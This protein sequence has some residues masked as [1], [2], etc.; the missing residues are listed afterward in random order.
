MRD[1]RTYPRLTDDQLRG[2]SCPTLFIAGEY[3]QFAPEEE[4]KRVTRLIPNSRY[5]VVPGGSHRP[6]MSR[7]NPVFVNDT[8]LQFLEIQS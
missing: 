2:I 5:V 4:L 3:D 6:H 1:W 7:E 8:I